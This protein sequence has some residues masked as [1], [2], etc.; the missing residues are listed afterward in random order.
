[1]SE[2]QISSILQGG[3]HHPLSRQWQA[4]RQLTKVRVVP[5]AASSSASADAV[6][7]IQP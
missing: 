7:L 4:E 2:T 1:M 3:Y 5:I 6:Q